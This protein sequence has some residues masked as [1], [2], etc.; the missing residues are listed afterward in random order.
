MLPNVL[1]DDDRRV[2]RE[3]P[4]DQV[5]EQAGQDDLRDIEQEVDILGESGTAAQHE[6][7]SADERVADRPGVERLGERFDGPHGF[8]GEE[9]AV[10]VHGVR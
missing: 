1:L 4:F 6:R 8:V 2:E 5:V 3:T 9:P 7:Q 10:S